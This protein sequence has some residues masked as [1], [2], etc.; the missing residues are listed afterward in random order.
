MF[1][2]FEEAFSRMKKA[3]GV[4]DVDE[5]ITRF[6]TQGKT[7][8]ILGDQMKRA[9]NDVRVLGDSKEKHQQEWEVVRYVKQKCKS[10]NEEFDFRYLGQDED[11]QIREKFEDMDLDM[12]EVTERFDKATGKLKG[13]ESNHNMIK[14]KLSL[15]ASIITGQN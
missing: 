14:K 13:L 12:E 1:V 4:S 9:E 15:M 3:A 11:V 10:T 6:S 2:E 7:S 5:V 8:D